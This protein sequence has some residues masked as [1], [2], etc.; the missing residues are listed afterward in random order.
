MTKG[1]PVM[2]KADKTS[3]NRIRK[4]GFFLLGMALCGFLYTSTAPAAKLDDFDPPPAGDPSAQR[5]PYIGLEFSD[6]AL[7]GL[8]PANEGAI[9]LEGDVQGTHADVSANNVV[10]S[11]GIQRGGG[12]YNIPT[13]SLPSPLYGARS[14]TQQML[15]FEE[16]GPETIDIDGGTPL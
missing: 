6:N 1:V 14:F 11:P 10:Q 15:L 2:R 5:Y 8:P 13:N 3:F 4:A 9:K 16:F 7:R 12:D